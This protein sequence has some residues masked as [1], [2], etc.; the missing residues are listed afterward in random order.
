MFTDNRFHAYYSDLIQFQL[1]CTAYSFNTE[2]LSPTLSR[3]RTTDVT[4]HAVSDRTR[5]W[6]RS[7]NL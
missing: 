7:R 1:E 5:K 3:Y 4:V 6:F 2:V